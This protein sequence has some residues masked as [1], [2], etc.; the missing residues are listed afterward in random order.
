MGIEREGADPSR[1]HCRELP[2]S[3]RFFLKHFHKL[4]VKI[5]LNYK[6]T[7]I[8]I[9]GG[10]ASLNQR[11]CADAL[12]EMHPVI[13]QVWRALMNQPSS[14]ILIIPD[15]VTCVKKCD[16]EARVYIGWTRYTFDF[17]NMTIIQKRFYKKRL[18]FVQESIN[19]FDGHILPV[20]WDADMRKIAQ[21][22]ETVHTWEELDPNIALLT[23]LSLLDKM[24]EIRDQCIL[25]CSK[26]SAVYTD[27]SSYMNILGNG[28]RAHPH[29][30]F[31][32][33]PIARICISTGIEIFADEKWQYIIGKYGSVRSQWKY[34]I[35]LLIL[36]YVDKLLLALSV[37]MEWFPSRL[38]VR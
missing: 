37:S 21:I 27:E 4:V 13:K 15:V 12:R 26:G 38:V 8:V 33:L 9:Q 5:Y 20:K 34:N 29:V 18:V 23:Q 28:G 32:Q 1:A 30:W 35:C 19:R 25:L 24:R 14:H 17:K 22:L 6:I 36:D 11:G 3:H 2:S 7:K 10:S 31:I 16:I